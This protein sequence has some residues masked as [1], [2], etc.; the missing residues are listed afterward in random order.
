MSLNNFSGLNNIPSLNNIPNL[1]GTSPSPFTYT[2]TTIQCLTPI[3]TPPVQPQLS[4]NDILQLQ[5]ATPFFNPS[6]YKSPNPI[7][8]ALTGT[9]SALDK[10]RGGW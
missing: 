3:Y 1:G 2:S 4:K 7:C 6:N 8:D 9:N 5:G 10:I